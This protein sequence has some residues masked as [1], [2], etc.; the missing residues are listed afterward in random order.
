MLRDMP[1]SK[2]NLTEGPHP[3]DT[4]NLEKRIEELERQLAD[5]RAALAIVVAAGQEALTAAS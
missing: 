3:V 1:L 5:A 4:E 2:R